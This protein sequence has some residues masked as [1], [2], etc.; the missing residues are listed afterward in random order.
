MAKLKK[1]IPTL[2]LLCA[3]ISTNLIFTM[4]KAF[5]VHE[6]QEAIDSIE[7][8]ENP[9]ELPLT[10]VHGTCARQSKR[11]SMQDDYFPHAHQ[12]PH[13]DKD[14]SFY[15]VYDGHG[16]RGQEAAGYVAQNLHRNLLSSKLLDIQ[17]RLA[18]K[19]A[20]IKTDQGFYRGDEDD[21]S[22]GTTAIVALVHRQT[23]YVANAGDS[24]GVLCINGKAVRVSQNHT[25]LSTE[26][27]V[28]IEKTKKHCHKPCKITRAYP[29]YLIPKIT[30][31]SAQTGKY[32]VH[33]AMLP[34]VKINFSPPLY[35]EPS[36][37]IGDYT[38]KPYVTA[39]P[40]IYQRTLTGTEEF[41][42]MGTDGFWD[43]IT[44]QAAVNFVLA[45]MR[46]YNVTEETIT[47]DIAHEIAQSLVDLSIYIQQLS[48][49][50]PHLS[51]SNDN[52]T[53]TIIFFKQTID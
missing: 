12:N 37:T 27:R 2:L 36:R 41:L 46:E 8:H 30:A 40:D 44:D 4:S 48:Q 18:I 38:C 33:E 49:E 14:T 29:D 42:I 19:Q 23:L 26:E 15:G 28:R 39:V 16:E 10:L 52:S 6:L 1:I 5:D 45:K 32:E 22:G 13:L 34:D 47:P 17:P 50:K 11:S 53:V 21:Y 20:F 7:R 24:P 25:A 9:F 3:T 35:I 51:S 31:C 43:A